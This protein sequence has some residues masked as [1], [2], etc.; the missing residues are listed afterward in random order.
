MNVFKTEQYRVG[1]A[2]N[3]SYLLIDTESGEAAVV[4]PSF[5]TAQVETALASSGAKLKYILLTHHHYDHVQEADSLSRKTGAKIVAHASSR[6][7]HDIGL[8]DGQSVSLGS[9]EVKLMHTPGHTSDSSCYLASGNLYTGDT[10]F[11]GE[12]GRVD[13]DDSDPERMYESLLVKLPALPDDVIVFPGH[14]YGKT[15]SSTIGMEKRS[16]YTMQKR[17][18]EAF[19]EFMIS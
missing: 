19:L 9:T 15:P 1:K 16:N 10:L 3:F 13:L 6:V 4:D 12:C 7:R 14:D 2:L 17:T 11:V 8:E 5:E 18:K